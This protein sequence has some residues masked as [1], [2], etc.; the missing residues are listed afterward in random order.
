MEKNRN[1]YAAGLPVSPVRKARSASMTHQI[2]ATLPEAAQT[3]P[4][5]A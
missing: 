4:A 1:K 5:F 2:T 3:A